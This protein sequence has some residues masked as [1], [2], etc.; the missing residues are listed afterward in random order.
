MTPISVLMCVYND[1]VF[2]NANLRGIVDS[3]DQIVI[4]E[5]SWNGVRGTYDYGKNER[6]ADGT[7]EIVEKFASEYPDK[8]LLIDS[9]EDEECSRNLGL[10]HCKNDWILH[11]DSDEFY[12]PEHIQALK[13]GPLEEAAKEGFDR[14]S[15]QEFVFYFNFH[16]FMTGRRI[17]MFD[18]SKGVH[19]ESG[20]GVGDILE[21]GTKKL[22]HLGS[23]TVFHFQ[24]I[25][26]RF[27]VVA[28]PNIKRERDFM[29]EMGEDPD[30][31]TRLG[32]WK[33]WLEQVYLKF[34]GDN[35]EEIEKKNRGSIHPWSFNY[36][37]HRNNPLNK[38]PTPGVF[39]QHVR[40]AKWFD[41]AER[42]LV[43]LEPNT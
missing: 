5:G 14:I 34:N 28:T 4:V 40:D 12:Y 15:F 22:L 25:G 16:Y 13:E 18:Q 30:K 24:W 38:I 29:I 23:V 10:S 26:D 7:R 41:F 6:S 2:T 1:A 9:L 42:G 17:R 31:V 20:N 37:E 19:Y 33:W 8:V 11:L 39:P 36:E 35:L 27:K 32:G 3:V 21:G 43:K